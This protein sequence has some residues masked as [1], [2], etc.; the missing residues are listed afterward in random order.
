MMDDSAWMEQAPCVLVMWGDQAP[1]IE[2]VDGQP[3]LPDKTVAL[4][5]RNGY[6]EVCRITFGPDDWPPLL[7]PG[8]GDGA[9][10]ASAFTKSPPTPRTEAMCYAMRTLTEWE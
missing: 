2:V 3:R 9:W 7:P 6:Q 1:G 5:R 10:L 8:E 4:S